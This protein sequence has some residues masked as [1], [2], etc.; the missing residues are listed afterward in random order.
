MGFQLSDY[1]ECSQILEDSKYFDFPLKV[2]N[3][4]HFLFEMQVDS[5]KILKQVI[6][7]IYNIN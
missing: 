1:L 5:M 2:E 7:I 4:D 6:F 3:C